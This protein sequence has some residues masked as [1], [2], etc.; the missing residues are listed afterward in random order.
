[1][2]D[3]QVN[4]QT[5]PD[6]TLHPPSVL[7]YAGP[8]DPGDGESIFWNVPAHTVILQGFIDV[9]SAGPAGHT[10]VFSMGGFG[11]IAVVPLD[12]VARNEWTTV[13]TASDSVAVQKI[14]CLRSGGT[15]GQPSPE[16]RIFLHVMRTHPRT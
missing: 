4:V 3:E 6:V 2:A 7:Y 9:T 10:G 8:M 12:S 1:M 14:N 11:V 15:P 13:P 5:T 16:V